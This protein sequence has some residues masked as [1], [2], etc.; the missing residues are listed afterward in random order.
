[1]LLEASSSMLE[2]DAATMDLVGGLSAS[3]VKD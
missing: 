1:M 2:K 3:M